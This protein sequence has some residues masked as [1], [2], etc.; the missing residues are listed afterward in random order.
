MLETILAT[1]VVSIATAL[2]GI[3]GKAVNDWSAREKK[4]NEIEEADN[5]RLDAIEALE[6]GINTVGATV[7]EGIKYAA[8]DGKLSSKDIRD[9][10]QKAVDEAVKITTN[11]DALEFLVH[12]SFETIGAIISGIV[13]GKK[14]RK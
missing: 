11:P 4:K 9:V 1:V 2:M 5:T 6:M 12:K 7:V 14:Q 13:Q 3:I 8:A 10:Q